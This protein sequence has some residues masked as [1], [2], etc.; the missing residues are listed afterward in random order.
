MFSTPLPGLESITGGMASA[1]S[2]GRQG[3]FR[4]GAFN[5]GHPS[6]FSQILPL[7]LIA[8]LAIFVIREVR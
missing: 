5:V 2:D 4:T 6:A 3:A 8:G 7:V 1:T